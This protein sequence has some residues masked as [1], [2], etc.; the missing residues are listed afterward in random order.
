MHA[1]TEP[2]SEQSPATRELAA[3]IR[4]RHR[5][6]LRELRIEV[7]EGGVILH[8]RAYSF[9]GKQVAQHEVLRRTNLVL[10]A[11]RIAVAATSHDAG[12]GVRTRP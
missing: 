8:G 6:L 11:N 3:D 5:S 7:V 1:L 10:L 2:P 4:W 9:Y 12:G